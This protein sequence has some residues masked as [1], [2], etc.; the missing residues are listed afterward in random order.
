M[1]KFRRTYKGRVS[2]S[3]GG[4]SATAIAKKALNAVRRI[5]PEI[6]KYDYTVAPGTGIAQ[7]G[8][9]FRPTFQLQQGVGYGQ[10]IG[11]E[12]KMT[13]MSAHILLA[14]G[15]ASFP[16]Q[17][18]RMIAFIDKEMDGIPCSVP[19]LLE[20]GAFPGTGLEVYSPYN[21]V[22]R[23]RFHVLSDETFSMVPGGSSLRQINKY[24]KLNRKCCFG[25]IGDGSDLDS[26]NGQPWLLFIT[27]ASA[28]V[29]NLGMSVR[30]NF[31]DS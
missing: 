1:P 21:T 30:V 14:G 18:V 9:L 10:R 19:D 17:A 15:S 28:N 12:I 26:Y 29:P 20:V 13:S 8:T 2:K 16:G 4:K 25:N 22:N 7:T 11:K 31:F 3:K 6:K 27:D 24:W 23:E 5:E